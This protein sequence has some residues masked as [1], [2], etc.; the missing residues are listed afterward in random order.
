MDRLIFKATALPKEI[1]LT[2]DQGEQRIYCL[3][4]AGR[5]FGAMLCKI[6]QADCS[7]LPNK[8]NS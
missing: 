4:P 7:T 3:R 2:G 1:V 6:E 5:K 8:E